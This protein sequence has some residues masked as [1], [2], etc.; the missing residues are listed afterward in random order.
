MN[1]CHYSA[2]LAVIVVHG[3]NIVG[4]HGRGNPLGSDETGKMSKFV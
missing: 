1:P 3:A 4:T 2:G